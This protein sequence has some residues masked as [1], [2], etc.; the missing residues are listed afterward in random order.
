MRWYGFKV[1]VIAAVSAT[2]VGLAAALVGSTG[3]GAD[4]ATPTAP[5]VT[6]Q[7]PSTVLDTA[8]N[9]AHKLKTGI[10]ES[11]TL[12][13]G[14]PSDAA[15]VFL[16][17]R[18]NGSKAGTLSIGS[19]G[20]T[21]PVVTIVAAHWVAET[22]VIDDPGTQLQALYSASKGATASATVQVTGYIASSPCF[23]SLAQVPEVDTMSGAGLSAPGSLAAGSSTQVDLSDSAAIPAVSGARLVTLT[24]T[25]GAS[26]ATVSLSPAD[27]IANAVLS[28]T[29]PAGQSQ[30]SVLFLPP[31]TSGAYVIAVSGGSVGVSITPAGWFTD[32][33][34][35]AMTDDLLLDTTLAVGTTKK[36]PLKAGHPVVLTLPNDVQSAAGVVLTIT[37]K[38]KSDA[39]VLVWDSST[40]KPKIPTASFRGG[41]TGYATIMVPQPADHQVSVQLA[42]GTADLQA[43]VSGDA[44]VPPAVNEPVPGV[45]TVPTTDQVSDV[46]NDPATD[47]EALTYTG[48]DQLNVGDVVVMDASDEQPDG[49]LGVVTDATQA[50]TPALRRKSGLSAADVTPADDG[51]AQTVDL[52]P[53][54]LTDAIPDA[55]MDSGNLPTASDD[56]PPDDSPPLPPDQPPAQG[57]ATPN[58]QSNQPAVQPA[59]SSGGALPNKANFSCSAGIS[60]SIT[61]SLKLSAGLDIGGSWSPWSG[62]TA[63]F[64]FNGSVSGSV[65]LNVNAGA[66]CSYAH[67]LDGPSLPTIRF[68]IGPVPVVVR[69]KLSMDVSASGSVDGAFKASAGA[70]VSLQTGVQYKNGGFSPYFTEQHS[71]PVTI[72]ARAGAN[73]T[74]EVKPRIDLQ[75]YGIA[76]PFA[77]LGASAT[78]TANLGANPW[79]SASAAIVGDVGFAI[80]VF[81]VHRTYTAPE[82]TFAHFSAG[83]AGGPYPGPAITTTSLPSGL[84]GSPYAVHLN[85]VN[86]TPPYSW[87]L[88]SGG[89]PNGL[90]LNVNGTISGTPTTVQAATFTV[91]AIDSSGNRTGDDQTL[92]ISIANPPP[93]PPP[94]TSV[95]VS[96]GARAPS[97][98]C[99]GDTS[100]TYVSI[101]WSGFGSGNHTITPLFDG[102]GNWCGTSCSNSLVRSG[103]SGTLTG[104]W[105]AGYCSQSHSVSANVDGVGSNTISTRDHGC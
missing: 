40:T 22:M 75:L 27:D 24:A 34:A 98:L 36:A 53:G 71:F 80:D 59:A 56:P 14:V 76:G 32:S 74:A 90:S 38:S 73:I 58:A 67:T 7:A 60:A 9:G 87:Y 86:G 70:N 11:V 21:V 78:G 30:G 15:A 89:L 88:V 85:A 29:I 23:T 25:A 69:P 17:V 20:S 91:R 1:S 65:A 8:G 43:V 46:V 64:G 49:Y 51:G 42:S 44:P 55:D 62:V 102:Q 37:E 81:G 72:Q 16:Q 13:S 5:C 45:V 57:G 18:V 26:T 19:S 66:S 105:A 4:A 54:A 3:A 97:N 6:S 33:T 39:G 12:P 47:N 94:G 63:S 79:W 84:T 52:R 101:S 103:S 77:E 35:F 48:P 2:V 104:Y 82:H 50:P 31:S 68:F 61:A 99:G 96:W 83:S 10:A 95:S 93:P 28:W 92:S 41:R 100:C